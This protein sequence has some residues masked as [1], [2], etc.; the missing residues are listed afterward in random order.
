MGSS[1]LQ[2]R[3]ML[4]LLFFIQVEFPLLNICFFVIGKDL[5]LTTTEKNYLK[6]Q[7]NMITQI[8]NANILE[9]NAPIKELNLWKKLNSTTQ[10]HETTIFF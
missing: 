7:S 10:G 1:S 6:M 8:I 9:V 3:G 4:E 2:Q 5:I